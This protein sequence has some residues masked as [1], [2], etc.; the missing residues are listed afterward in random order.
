MRHGLGVAAVFCGA[1]ACAESPSSQPPSSA[2]AAAS[3]VPAAPSGLVTVVSSA[4]PAPPAAPAEPKRAVEL[5]A[6]GD[7]DMGRLRGQ[8]LLRDPAAD[9]LGAFSELF[10]AADLRFAN[11][12]STITDRKGETQAPWSTL[13]F[14]APPP[15]ADALKRARFDLVSLANNHAWDYGEAGLFETFV[16]LEKV[17]VPWVGA[18]RTR[19]AAHAP[20]VLERHGQRLAFVAVTGIWN[21]HLEPHPG[22]QRIADAQPA[23]L[24][25]AIAA[26]RALP[27]VDRVIVSYH[28][29]DEY[30]DE[31]LPGTRALL[32]GALEAGADAVIGHHPHVVQRVELHAGRPI[33]YSLG[34]LLMRM[35]SGK[36]WTEYGMLARLTIPPQR[37][38]P[39]AI[40]VCP[41]RTFGL[42]AIPLAKDSRRELSERFFRMRFGQ[43]LDAGAKVHAPSALTLGETGPDGCAALVPR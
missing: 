15:A 8:V 38:A 12:E 14:T 27:G 7:I 42:D 5:I 43:L 30:V 35:S 10:A 40:G 18:G 4:D 16:R 21:Q 25:A 22:K 34:N 17:G 3:A 19:D 13:V 29:G 1:W 36:P 33:F 20:V 23:D 9:G 24:E 6:G 26:A 28:G 2:Y 41:L 31:P 11:L 37:D 39:I 32:I